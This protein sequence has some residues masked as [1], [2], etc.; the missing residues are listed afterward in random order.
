MPRHVVG[1]FLTAEDAAFRRHKGFDPEMIRRALAQDLAMGSFVKGA[2]TLSQQL[3]KNLFLGPERTLGRKL[4]EL[5]LTWRLEQ[6]LSKDRILELYLNIVELGP[7]I[8]GVGRAAESYFGKPVSALTPLEAGHLASLLPNPVGYARR[9]RDGRVDESWMVKLLD[10][11]SRM[12]RN[13][14]LSESAFSAAQEAR[15]GLLRRE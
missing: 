2:S 12:K 9:F 13:G 3:A 8:R 4:A 1:A 6:V 10:L 15:L 7:G 11:L 14:W 5:V